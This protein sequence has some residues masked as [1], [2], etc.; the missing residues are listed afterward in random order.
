LLKRQK[1]GAS[2]RRTPGCRQL[3]AETRSAFLQIKTVFRSSDQSRLWM[4]HHQMSGVRLWRHFQQPVRRFTLFKEK[5]MRTNSVTISVPLRTSIIQRMADGFAK[6]I[7]CVRKYYSQR[8]NIAILHSMSER[9]LKDIGLS[10][11]D[12]YRIT[13]M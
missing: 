13:R 12:I 10:R 2:H 8:C 7:A 4:T 3:S 11:S 5:Q 6:V 9:E 1:W